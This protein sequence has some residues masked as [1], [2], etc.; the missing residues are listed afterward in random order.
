MK[1]ISDAAIMTNDGL[2]NF[3]PEKPITHAELH[4]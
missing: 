1:T 3:N 4:P 2:G